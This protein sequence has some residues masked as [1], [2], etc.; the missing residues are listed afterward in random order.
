MNKKTDHNQIL[1]SAQCLVGNERNYVCEALEYGRLSGDGKF[2][3]RCSENLS[4]SIGVEVALTTP[5][6]TH[7]LELAALLINIQN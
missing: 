4:K 1:F 5:S 7:A 2:T 6:G 3:E